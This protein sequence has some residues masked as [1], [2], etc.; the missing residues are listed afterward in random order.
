MNDMYTIF[1]L[2]KHKSLI[3]FAGIR[4]QKHVQDTSLCKSVVVL[5]RPW[6]F[7][8]KEYAC[9]CRRHWFDP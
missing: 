1:G 4:L 9:Q 8:G 7:S 3:Y 6:W 5:G 2:S